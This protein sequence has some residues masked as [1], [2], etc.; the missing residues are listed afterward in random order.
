MTRK[1]I[2]L[3][4]PLFILTIVMLVLVLLASNL[5]WNNL[6]GDLLASNASLLDANMT[7]KQPNV[8]EDAELTAFHNNDGTITIIVNGYYSHVIP[9]AC[10]RL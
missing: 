9:D 10:R 4:R 6:V 5:R 3:E 8:V 1:K 7:T 2:N